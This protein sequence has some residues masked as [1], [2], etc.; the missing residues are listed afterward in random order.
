MSL[1][2]MNN[3]VI[4]NLFQMLNVTQDNQNTLLENI[5]GNY[6]SYAKIQYIANQVN[7]L[8]NEANNILLNHEMNNELKKIKCT[9]KKV[10]G[11]YYYVYEKNN[12]QF[13]SLISPEEWHVPP[14]K[15]ICKVFFDYDYNFY[16]L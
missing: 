2:N 9:F 5:K 6:A 11:N 12:N 3:H 16:T 15:F 13:L 4:T 7:M 8:K 1:S 14:E 10:P